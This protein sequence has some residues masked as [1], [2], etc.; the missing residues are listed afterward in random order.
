MRLLT[1][2]DFDGI[3]CAVLLEE[4]GVVD[5]MVYAH[6][7]D[8]QDGKVKVTENDVLAN[9]PYVDGAGMWF[10]HHSSEDIRVM[11][12][13]N[14][15]GKVG[16]SPSTA[17]LIYDYYGSEKLGK[18]KEMLKYCDKMDSADLTEYEIKNPAGWIM[19]GLICD[20]RTG[21][22]YHKDF[23]TSNLELMQDLTRYIARLSIDEILKLPDVVERVEMYNEKNA[24]YVE[25]IEA[26]SRMDG[27]ILV[28]DTRDKQ[29]PPGN[30]FMEYA[31][32]PDANVSVRLLRAKDPDTTA[33]S[34]GYSIINKSATADVGAIMLKYGGGGH[35]KVGTCQ[36]PAADVEGVL[37]EILGLLR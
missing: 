11:T 37:P 9:V 15:R 19:L 33:I 5:E 2:S 31:L 34:V 14:V 26:N 18:Y 8:L 20:P 6:P 35:R 25:F 12:A 1:R 36:V 17:H 30:R 13:G 16:D 29:V 24:E 4:L 23:Q 3:C 32:F 22:G 21:L 28:I 10:D 7:K 27:N